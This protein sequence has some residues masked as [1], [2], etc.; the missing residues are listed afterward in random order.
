MKGKAVPNKTLLLCMIDGLCGGQ[1]KRKFA[2]SA[3]YPIGHCS[4]AV[5]QQTLISH[6]I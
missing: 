1:Y 5:Q 6:L 3:A 2:S 4:H